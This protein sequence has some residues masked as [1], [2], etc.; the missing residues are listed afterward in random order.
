MQAGAHSAMAGMSSNTW[1]P[2][3]KLMIMF[4]QGRGPLVLHQETVLEVPGLIPANCLEG[5]MTR[6][7]GG[8]GRRKLGQLPVSNPASPSG[9]VDPDQ[10]RG[11]GSYIVNAINAANTVNAINSQCNRLGLCSS[12]VCAV[13]AFD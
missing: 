11:W 2:V 4:L 6:L 5:L 13:K 1:L 9:S 12:A 3:Y 8:V 10:G 7:L